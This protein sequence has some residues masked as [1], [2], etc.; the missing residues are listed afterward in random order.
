[1]P[2]ARPPELFDRIL[3]TP[4]N[5]AKAGNISAGGKANFA[6]AGFDPIISKEF[7]G[8]DGPF[9]A[10]KNPFTGQRFGRFTNR[11]E[12]IQVAERAGVTGNSSSSSRAAATGASAN[13]ANVGLSGTDFRT[14]EQTRAEAELAKQLGVD[15]LSEVKP[16][17]KLTAELMER[18]DITPGANEFLDTTGKLL[19]ENREAVVS[20]AA[21]GQVVSEAPTL[22]A[23][24]GVATTV[25]G[26]EKEMT[27]ASLAA[28]T[29]EIDPNAIEGTV[30][31]PSLATAQTEELDER[32]TTSFQLKQLFEGEGNFTTLFSKP[33]REAT[34]RMLSRGLGSSSM[35]AAAI[36]QS[37][38]ESGIPIARE[39]ANKFATIQLQNL[40]NKHQTVLANASVFAA[41]DQTNVGVRLNSNIEN[42]KNFLAIDTANLNNAQ[43]E[44]VLN[45]QARN[46]F[47]LSDQA[48]SNAIENLNVTTEAQTDQFFSQ[49]GVQVREANANRTTAVEQF[50]AG[51]RNTLEV[52]NSKQQDL[53]ERFN[54]EQ[55]TA[56]AA[57]NADHRRRITLQN[58]ANQMVVNEVNAREIN[59]LNVREYQEQYLN[60]RD[61]AT[62]IF[63]TAES[64]ENRAVQLATSELNASAIRS[65]GGGG[66]SSIGSSLIGG[67]ATIIGSIF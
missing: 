15:A 32:A 37:T 59:G 35:A 19:G 14:P 10:V 57:T 48:A 3:G 28:P 25:A 9:F 46:Q 12:A 30:T 40:S 24:Q 29:V 58:A 39:D 5:I 22:A 67:A 45:Q 21:P 33:I 6:Q 43:Q 63:A 23:P 66:G 13:P 51:Q 4:E 65:S 53:R 64:N 16:P 41:M 52:F 11:N 49:L 31:A 7:D 55:Q 38:I 61:A 50:N 56:I 47:L 42:A 2:I 17:E 54:A 18:P 27:A 62:R 34:N 20:T 36:I 60:Y 44:E 26:Q 8:E 1:M